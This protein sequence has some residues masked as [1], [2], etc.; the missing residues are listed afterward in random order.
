MFFT[1]FVPDVLTQAKMTTDTLFYATTALFL[2][3]KFGWA[4]GSMLKEG[5]G[6]GKLCYRKHNCC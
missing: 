5:Y 4:L 6:K 1:E 3:L 2:L